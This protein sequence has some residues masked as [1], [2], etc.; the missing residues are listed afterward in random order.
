MLKQGIPNF[1]HAPSTY[2]TSLPPNPDAN[3][4]C[5]WTTSTGYTLD[6]TDLYGSILEYSSA[7]S[8]YTYYYSPCNDGVICTHNS[9]IINN[10]RAMA[11]QE[12]NGFCES[13]LA[14]YDD[15]ITPTY[16][17]SSKTFTFEY[18]NGETSGVCDNPREF[19]IEYECGSLNT[20]Y[21]V[22]SVTEVASCIY[23]MSISTYLACINE[24]KTTTTH[25]PRTT[26]IPNDCMFGMY[27]YG[28]A[29][30][31]LNEGW[32]LV[33]IE[34]FS[35]YRREFVSYYNHNN[36]IY[37]IKSFYCTNCCFSLGGSYLSIINGNMDINDCYVIPA[38]APYTTACCPGDGYIEGQNYIFERQQIDQFLNNINGKNLTFGTYDGCSGNDE[39]PA[40]FQK[41]CF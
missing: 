31:I 12:K 4:N 15:T 14:K 5:V 38:I 17:A 39:N 1:D 22:K 33:T 9:S 20:L 16:T 40:I 13:Y 18:N 10:I 3:S 2:F 37:A 29:D 35:E 6:L 30:D 23:K 11:T 24:T 21:K 27:Y 25:I 41:N 28:S 19:I 34:E 8:D 26:N 32:Q 7:L 36:G